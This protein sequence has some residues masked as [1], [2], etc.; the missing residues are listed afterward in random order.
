M[1]LAF[2]LGACA[3]GPRA[4]QRVLLLV[5]DTTHG[6]QLGC[7]GGPAG[8][9]PNLDALAAGGMRFDRALANTT[10]TLPSTAS[11]M[12]GRLPYSHGVLTT[13]DRM[14]DDAL[15]VAELF[16]AAGWRTAAF[17]QMVYASDGYGLGQGF[18]HARYYSKESER[19]PDTEVIAEVLQWMDETEGEPAFLYVHLRRP[20]SPY[21][22][23]PEVW[24][25]LEQ[26]CPLA[27]SPAAQALARADSMLIPEGGLSAAQRDHVE[28]LYLGNLATIDHLLEPLL[29]RA[30]ASDDTLVVV[31]SDHGEGLGQHGDYGHGNYLHAENV[32]I[33][34]IFVGP[35][36]VPG[37]DTHP[38]SSVDVLPTLAALCGLPVPTGHDFDG[39]SLASR[40]S[41]RWA[42]TPSPVVLVGKHRTNGM[43]EVGLVEG[44]YKLVL[45]SDG[46]ARLHHRRDDRA[47]RTDLRTE[48]SEVTVRM[49]DAAVDYRREHVLTAG[50]RTSA[51][52]PTVTTAEQEALAELG[53]LGEDH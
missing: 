23:G 52:A 13:G 31:T 42:G 18:E 1:L 39:R 51:D 32:D 53:Y 41:G 3:D 2:A 40:L 49:R 50:E 30:Q 20:H 27:E 46:M 29:S 24:S 44:D 37:V 10:W 47:E 19:P 26:D 8:L 15:L 34:L 43:P 5:L 35:G 9:T 25:Q 16:A 22:P 21:Q 14:P 48:R 7:Q 6:D 33:P 38:A 12:S 11:L 36:V 28:H 17:V 45:A 4:P